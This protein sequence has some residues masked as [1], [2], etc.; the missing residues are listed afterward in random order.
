MKK[1]NKCTVPIGT[2][3]KISVEDSDNSVDNLEW[4]PHY[5][6][7]SEA[8]EADENM[9]VP[10]L[11]SNLNKLQTEANAGITNMYGVIPEPGTRD[12]TMT[13]NEKLNILTEVAK[14]RHLIKLNT[15][16]K[17]RTWDEHKRLTMSPKEKL[18]ILSKRFSDIGQE[19][20]ILEG[21]N[22]INE[23]DSLLGLVIHFTHNYI[24]PDDRRHMVLE[25]LITD[26]VQ[27]K[28]DTIRSIETNPHNHLG[29]AMDMTHPYHAPNIK[30]NKS[31]DVSIT[32][33][34]YDLSLEEAINGGLIHEDKKPYYISVDIA[35]GNDH[36][37]YTPLKGVKLKPHQ[38]SNEISGAYAS[39]STLLYNPSTHYT[40]TGMGEL[41]L[42]K[43]TRKI[44]ENVRRRKLIVT[45]EDI[46]NAHT[47]IS[48]LG[49]CFPPDI[50][51]IRGKEVWYYHG[52]ED[53][54]NWN[55]IS[56]RKLVKEIKRAR[57]R[58]Y[59]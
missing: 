49:K 17:P 48:I 6:N 39:K 28:E 55:K 15:I 10:D 50:I 33:G 1:D 24:E 41:N 18:D 25:E 37:T 57:R 26:I 29:Q 4:V 59:E 9:V 2:V 34:P 16:S 35:K 20:V 43:L 27:V 54:M 44:A 53:F 21:N 22:I 12:Y 23:L 46:G 3:T 42:T 36:T 13:D 5:Q 58:R 11:L 52:A 45:D 8:R 51:K 32:I 14:N 47:R 19:V 31:K 38:L 30:D 40:L 56:K 7:R